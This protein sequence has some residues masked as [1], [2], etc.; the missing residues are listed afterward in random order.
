MRKMAIIAKYSFFEV[1]KSNVFIGSVIGA[2][3]MFVVTWIA[4]EFTYG[5]PAKISL[6]FGLGLMTLTNCGVACFLGSAIIFDEI[7]NRTL[8]MVLSRPVGRTSFLL[9]KMSGMLFFLLLNSIILGLV[10]F[11][12]FYL[13]RGN[14][15]SDILIAMSF[16]FLESVW[17]LLMVVLFSLLTNKPMAIIYTIC[18]YFLGHSIS[19]TKGMPFVEQNVALKKVIQG[20]SYFFPDFSRINMKEYVIYFER[21][22]ASFV[23]NAFLYFLLYS[24]MLVFL[25]CMVFHR[26]NLD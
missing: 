15:S 23:S 11:L 22:E 2:A 17:V 12:N 18:L 3:F 8:Y 10:T 20:Y 1:L 4:A 19:F 25:N 9:G 14:Y 5:V 16:T 6:D 24:L 21:L 13:S 7:E 26:K